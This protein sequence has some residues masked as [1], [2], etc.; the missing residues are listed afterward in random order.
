MPG[1]RL[2][3]GERAVH[4]EKVSELYL[5]G[6]HHAA[7]AAALGFTRQQID[8]DV[9]QLHIRWQRAAHANID[10]HKSRELAKVDQ[11][12]RTYWEAW[13]RSRLPQETSQSKRR[14]GNRASTEASQ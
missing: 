10:Q 12:E 9:K 8:Y 3:N 13:D 11:L 7:I 4:V 2:T 1:P 14:E 6:W 5:K